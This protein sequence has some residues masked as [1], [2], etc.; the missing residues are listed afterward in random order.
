MGRKTRNEQRETR[1]RRKGEPGTS[2]Q[3]SRVTWLSFVED[4]STTGVNIVSLAPLIF[5]ISSSSFSSSFPFSSILVSLSRRLSS[6]SLNFRKGLRRYE[7]STCKPAGAPCEA[8][9]R[10]N[11]FCIT[12]TKIRRECKCLSDFFPLMLNVRVIRNE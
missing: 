7:L 8:K 2:S 1:R 4:V 6:S 5:P 11:V 9:G 10:A 12:I 3:T